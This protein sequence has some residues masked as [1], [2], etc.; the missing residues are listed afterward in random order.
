M[1]LTE[2]FSERLKTIAVGIDTNMNNL[3]SMMT[4]EQLKEAVQDHS[5]VGWTNPNARYK[6]VL[7]GVTRRNDKWL[8]DFEVNNVA[9]ACGEYEA[10][11]LEIQDVLGFMQSCEN[12]L[13]HEPVLIN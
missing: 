2:A 10:H 11:D 3:L 4:T 1:N 5:H 7:M 8:F 12:V 9:Y 6:M 13:L